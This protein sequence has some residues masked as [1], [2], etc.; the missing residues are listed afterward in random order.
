VKKSRVPLIAILFSLILLA[1]LYLFG[2][3]W[4]AFA[5][6]VR[7]GFHREVAGIRF[8]VP[9]F[10]QEESASP[11]RL[12]IT[13]YRSPVRSPHAFITVDRLPS[14]PKP[15][16]VP[17][18]KEEAETL[19][20]IPMGQ[21]NAILASQAG[22]CMEYSQDQL[23]LAGYSIRTLMY[24]ECRFGND[25]DVRFDGSQDSAP[26]FYSFIESARKADR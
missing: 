1:G 19:G 18:A 22:T 17:L 7:H 26:E 3:N 23:V 24:I 8:S 5:W 9:L 12:S 13:E 14:P 21:R 6:H 25:L 16:L 2:M 11:N 15:A 10:Y 20:L 4:F